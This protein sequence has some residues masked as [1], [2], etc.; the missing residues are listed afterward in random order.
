MRK[1]HARLRLATVDG[2]V[3][4][5]YRSGRKRCR[6]IPEAASTAS[7]R[8]AGTTPRANQL[9]TVLCAPKP[10]SRARAVCPPTAS[11]ASSS[12]SLLMDA[13]N[14]QTVY[15]VNADSG[16]GGLE[17]ARMAKQIYQP[18]AFWRRLQEALAGHPR[19]PADIN[20]N[21]LATK[22]GMSQGTVYRWF[23][24]VGFP[25]LK[26]ALDLAEDGGVCVDW[27]LNNVKPKYPISKDPLL[28]ELFEICEDLDEEGRLR[29]L[30]AA[31]GELLQ[32]QEEAADEKRVSR[33]RS[34]TG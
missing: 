15:L 16:N 6:E 25:E 2:V 14:A 23:R 4:K 3:S 30:R 1:T 21:S 27:L 10:K 7:T 9:D 13:I 8:S 33:G 18:S 32:Q 31:R 19:Y 29:V 22:L 20:P 26:L 17:N 12:A 5:G 34:N 28:K 24:G 11:H